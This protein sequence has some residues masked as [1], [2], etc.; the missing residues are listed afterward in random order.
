MYINIFIVE[1]N[2]IEVVR[3]N[4][5]VF[6]NYKMMFKVF[7]SCFGVFNNFRFFL[8]RCSLDNILNEIYKY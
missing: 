7:G 4:V 5:F 1:L 8:E 6:M 3:I 2:N